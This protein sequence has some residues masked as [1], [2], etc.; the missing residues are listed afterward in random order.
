MICIIVTDLSQQNHGRHKTDS[1]MSHFWKVSV[2]DSVNNHLM[3]P[4]WLR[5]WC[6]KPPSLGVTTRCKRLTLVWR[7]A[8][9]RTE[10]T[11]TDKIWTT[12]EGRGPAS[13]I[14]SGSSKVKM[15]TSKL[16]GKYSCEETVLTRLQKLATCVWR[17]NIVLY[18]G[19]KG[20]L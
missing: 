10:Y 3:D 6:T 14:L 11:N 9:S 20:Q 18:A 1:P 5:G 7:R 17:R 15:L 16:I 2:L 13:A 4:A 8:A 19:Q 12:R